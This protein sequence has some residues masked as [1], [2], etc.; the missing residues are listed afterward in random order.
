MSPL[1]ALP[2]HS[3]VRHAEA[4]NPETE[5]QEPTLIDQLLDEQRSLSAVER[6]SQRHGDMDQP[7]QQKYYRD[8]LPANPPGPGQQYAF[9]VNLDTCSGCKACVAACHSLNGLDEGESWRNVGLLLTTN[10]EGYQR[11][12]TTACH[13]CVDPA[14]MNGCPVLAYDKD[15]STGIVRHLDDQCIGCQ[16][17]V[18]KCPYDVPKYSERLGIVRKC[19]MCS[20]RLAASEAP[21][22]VQSC[23][24]EAIRITVVDQQ[25]ARDQYQT[26]GTKN[27]DANSFLPT[28]PAPEYTLPTTLYHTR[29]AMPAGVVAGDDG[30]LTPQHAHWPLIFMLVLLQAGTGCF[31]V[32]AAL[33]YGAQSE[34]IWLLTVAGAAWTLTGLFASVFHL[35]RPMGAWRIF[36]GWKKSWLSREA[37]VFGMFGGLAATVPAIPFIKKLSFLPPIP[38]IIE[39]NLLAMAAM[40]GLAGTF[41]S[42]MLYHDTRRAYWQFILTFTRFSS[43]MLVLGLATALAVNASPEH[44]RSMATLLGLCSI[45]KLIWELSLTRRWLGKNRGALYRSARL[46]SEPLGVQYR[47]RVALLIMGGAVI[48]SLMLL[49]NIHP[50]LGALAVLLLTGSELI[51]RYLFFTAVSPDKMPG[52]PW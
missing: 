21:A 10:G 52:G 27:Q 41:A 15:P 6:F 22:C 4:M 44:T 1:G 7:L 14:C 47:S 25:A 50:A 18:L 29:S 30:S 23:P 34:N 13:H 46:L 24:N 49:G 17:C 19:D 33:V 31:L 12:V 8:L 42:I 51:E 9:E 43:T 40:A 20:N 2:P 45:G 36:L 5:I 37:M 32:A 48:P 39:A 28:S 35:G 3:K 16:Y 26:S 11:T 38:P